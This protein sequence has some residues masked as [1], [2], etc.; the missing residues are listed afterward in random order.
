MQENVTIVEK[1]ILKRLFKDTNYQK[2]SDHC[3]YANM[4][5]GATHN[6]CNLKFIVPNKIPTVFDNGSNFHYYF[7][8][9]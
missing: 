9:K 8:I 1:N 4:Y 2:V 5:R 3:N 7:I 6:I